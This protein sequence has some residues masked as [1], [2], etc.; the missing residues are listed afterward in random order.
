MAARG[1]T[2]EAIDP[3]LRYPVFATGA[4]ARRHWVRAG[5]AQDY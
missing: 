2:S 4:S 1:E 5:D 3:I